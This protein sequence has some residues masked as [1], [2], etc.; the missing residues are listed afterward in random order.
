MLNFGNDQPELKKEDAKEE[1]NETE[2]KKNELDFD[3]FI[4]LIKGK[5]YLK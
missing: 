1:V 4:G 5:L 2:L 3:E